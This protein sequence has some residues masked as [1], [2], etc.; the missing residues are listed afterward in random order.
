MKYLIKIHLECA[1]TFEI[2]LDWIPDHSN[3]RMRGVQ[4]AWNLTITKPEWTVYLVRTHG[5][6]VLYDEF[7]SDDRIYR[8]HNKK[9]NWNI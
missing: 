2:R 5:T 4:P 6:T 1:K 3:L 9:K 7:L 8:S